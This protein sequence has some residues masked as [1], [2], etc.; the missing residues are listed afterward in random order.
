MKRRRFI[1]TT[2]GA[3]VAVGAAACGRDDAPHVIAQP[4]VQWRMSTAF[5][6]T[7]DV[8]QGGAQRVAKIV[9]E[10][11]G[12]RFRIEVFPG[13]QI[14]PPFEV[15]EAASKG[16]IEAFMAVTQYW[17][18]REPALEWFTTIPFGMDPA[19]M[20]AWYHQGD[21]LTLWE[22]AYAPFN[23][24]PRPGQGNAPQM[25]GWFRRKI[26]TIGDFKGLKMR[27][28]NLGGRVVART[29]ATTVLT[30]AAE[31]Y[32][33][34]ERG[35]IDAAE[36]VCPDQDMQLGL[37]KTARYYY[38]PGWHE[39]G[40]TTEFGFNKKAYEALPVDLQ[41]AL[42]Y[43]VAATQLFGLTHFNVKNAN[44]L[45]RL[46]AEF[47]GKVEVLPFPATVLRDLKK[48]SVEVI[49]EESER[50]ALAR[51]V[52]ASYSKFQALYASWSRAS[53]GPYHQFV[54]L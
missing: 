40:T 26:N 12:G 19:G 34:L 38:Y 20:A 2:G 54:A 25:G 31:I 52:H 47:K 44:A 48:L 11:S 37:H 41:R 53:E 6:A 7:L 5:P 32:A 46:K 35:V 42:D 33:A 43:A 45:E 30:P 9:E 24:V 21:G 50:T 8:L 15:F 29:G 3:L 51:K 23:L 49:R 27:I 18:A 10:V 36:W 14:M 13:G 17:V 28:V 1:V 22:E 16:T 39:P 4:K